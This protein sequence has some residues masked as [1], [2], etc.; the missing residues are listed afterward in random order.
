MPVAFETCG[1][2]FGPTRF[3]EETFA[4]TPLVERVLAEVG[5]PGP[6]H[7]HH[8]D[9]VL[10]WIHAEL[11]EAVERD[12]A[13]V[14]LRQPVDA[15][16]LHRGRVQLVD[17]VRDLHVEEL[18]RV[19]EPRQMVG[20]PEDGRA[21]RRVVGADA[22]E[23]AGSVV[24]PVRADVNLGVGPVDELAVHP[25]LGRLAHASKPTRRARRSGVRMR[26][27]SRGWHAAERVR[28]RHR[29]ARRVGDAAIVV[30]SGRGGSPAAER[31]DVDVVD[32]PGGEEPGGL[33]A[34][35]DLGRAVVEVQA[36]EKMRRRQSRKRRLP[37][38]AERRDAGGE[39]DRALAR[40]ND[41]LDDEDASV[42]PRFR[43]T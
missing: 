15:E 7:D 20:Q 19:V 27:S 5:A 14:G 6:A 42:E 21:L 30:A 4:R 11:S 12:R 8:V 9:R 2:V 29:V 43:V 26:I 31:I 10:A 34:E 38:R 16:E 13:Q 28:E 23:H 36:G 17:G 41:R 33:E 3:H 40:P 25:D 32:L 1:I 24:E 18:G 37:R 22:L 39:D 35:R